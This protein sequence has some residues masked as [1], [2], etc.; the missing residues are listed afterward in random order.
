MIE[1]IIYIVGIFIHIIGFRL[2]WLRDVDRY[3]ES[4][5][6]LFFH[7]NIHNNDGSEIVQTVAWTM[8]WPGVLIGFII[9][10]IIKLGVR[11]IDMFYERWI[12]S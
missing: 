1:L 7:E 11:G 12:K 6:T 8:S 2:I 5:S 4:K 3:K 9:Y 10:W